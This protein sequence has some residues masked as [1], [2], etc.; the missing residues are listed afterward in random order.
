MRQLPCRNVP[1]D[2]WRD[3]LCVMSALVDVGYRKHVDCFVFQHLQR[4]V[5]GP[6]ERHVCGVCFRHVQGRA[7]PGRVRGLR[8]WH[9]RKRHWQCEV[10]DVCGRW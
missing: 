5:Y 6:R 10:Q 3:I 7:R 9:I 8:S 2:D 4:R 1:C